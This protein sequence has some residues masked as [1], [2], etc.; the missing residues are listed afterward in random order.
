MQCMFKLLWNK[1]QDKSNL[2]SY[3]FLAWARKRIFGNTDFDGISIR[4]QESLSEYHIS[5]SL[6]A[7]SITS[8]SLYSFLSLKNIGFKELLEYLNRDFSVCLNLRTPMSSSF[9]QVKFY[10]NE[11]PEWGMRIECMMGGNFVIHSKNT[12]CSQGLFQKKRFVI[13]DNDLYKCVLSIPLPW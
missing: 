7:I 3:D 13:T 6:L 12:L 1:L 10:A 11:D 2:R 5:D 4:G 8:P 9:S